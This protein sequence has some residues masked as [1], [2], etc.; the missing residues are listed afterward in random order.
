MVSTS[1][2][3]GMILSARPF[4]HAAVKPVAVLGGA[5]DVGRHGAASVA[6]GHVRRDNC[7]ISKSNFTISLPY[8]GMT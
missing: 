8:Q 4:V 3:P 7:N 1:L 6:L 5:F 2:C